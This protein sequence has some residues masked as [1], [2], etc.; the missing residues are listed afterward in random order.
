MEEQEDDDDDDNQ[1]EDEPLT[2]N[3]R[4]VDYGVDNSGMPSTYFVDEQHGGL[5]DKSVRRLMLR[6]IYLGMLAMITTWVHLALRFIECANIACI[7]TLINS[8]CVLLSFDITADGLARLCCWCRQSLGHSHGY[9]RSVRPRTHAASSSNNEN[10]G[11]YS[12]PAT[13]AAVKAKP[14]LSRAEAGAVAAP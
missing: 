1:N 8:M 5:R 2:N 14:P 4:S 6:T 13:P 11:S 10:G 12:R 3:Q 7:E 9:G